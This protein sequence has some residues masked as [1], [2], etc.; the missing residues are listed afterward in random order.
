VFCFSRFCGDVSG[1]DNVFKYLRS[2][3]GVWNNGKEVRITNIVAV[4]GI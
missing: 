2:K 1:E 4:I 3:P